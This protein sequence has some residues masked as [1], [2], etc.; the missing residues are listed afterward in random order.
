MVKFKESGDREGEI[1]KVSV[2]MNCYNG[3]KYLKEAIESVYSQTYQDW[4]IIF[5]DNA[6]TDSSAEIAKGYD[7]KLRYFRGE[8]TVPLYAARN[9]A[10]KK[11]GG[12]YIAILDCDD[13]W[14]PTKLEEQLPLLEKDEEVGLVYSDAL[15]FNE[16][17]KEKRSFKFRKPYRGNIFSELLLCNFINTQTV[18]IRKKI[19]DSLNYWFDNRLNIAGD[20]DAYLRISYKWKVDYVD[21]PLVRYRVHRD[22]TTYK[23]GRER[24]IIELD[25]MMGNLKKTI[26]DFECEY[27]EEIK[28]LKRR[29]DIQLSL[30]DWENGDKKKARKRL[31]TYM[32]DSISYMI[33]YFLTYLSYRY[34]FYPCYKVY[35]KNLT[36]D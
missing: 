1:P 20:L 21:R 29:R 4:E 35:T 13:L 23:E 26:S 19:F 10:L 18:V 3:E 12:K 5:W 30:L 7:G 33:L 27:H 31:Q 15:L 36:A 16:K 11:T 17:G 8:K 6:S 24:L 25:I 14:L 9:Y 32:Y 34:F 28:V 22:G 2:I